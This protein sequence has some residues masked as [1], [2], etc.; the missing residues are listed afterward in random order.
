MK[1][2]CGAYL[3]L[4]AAH[5]EHANGRGGVDERLEDELAHLGRVGDGGEVDAR[6]ARVARHANSLEGELAAKEVGIGRVILCSRTS[7]T[8]ASACCSSPP[9]R[10]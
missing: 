2:S 10:S 6:D 4:D 8:C 3:K 9:T 5:E 1:M 7:I